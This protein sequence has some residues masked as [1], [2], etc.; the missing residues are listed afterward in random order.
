MQSRD[1]RLGTISL[2]NNV[3]LS[4]V[5]SVLCDVNQRWSRSLVKLSKTLSMLP[6]NLPSWK[7]VHMSDRCIFLAFCNSS[8]RDGQTG[9]CSLTLTPFYWNRPT[10]LSAK[11]AKFCPIYVP[12]LCRAIL[13]LRDCKKTYACTWKRSPVVI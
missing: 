8:E 13:F 6:T 7:I 2:T 12:Y 4:A 3:L 10:E 1:Q 11:C 9:L 5:A